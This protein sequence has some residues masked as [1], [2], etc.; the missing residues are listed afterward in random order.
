[1]KY[2]EYLQQPYTN[3]KPMK[4]ILLTVVFSAISIF[5]WGLRGNITPWI[6]NNNGYMVGYYDEF[7]NIIQRNESSDILNVCYNADTVWVGCH[8]PS[9]FILGIRDNDPLLYRAQNFNYVF[10]GNPIYP[11]SYHDNT[12]V[13]MI[14]LAVNE[15]ALYVNREGKPYS[16]TTGINANINPIDTFFYPNPT[17]EEININAPGKPG[18]INIYSTEGKLPQTASNT[19]VIDIQNLDMGVYIVEILL[20][21]TPFRKG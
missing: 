4:S 3:Q 16:S 12:P 11:S 1:M 14:G 8:L 5:S 10:S 6:L 13:L 18:K 20:N 21:T 15:V 9:S 2:V 19:S 17:S 7:F